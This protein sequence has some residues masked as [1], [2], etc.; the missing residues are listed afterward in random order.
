MGDFVHSGPK[1]ASIPVPDVADLIARLE[2]GELSNGLDILIEL[3]FFAAEPIA[4]RAN[5]A[6]T[7]V[8]YT[9]RDGRE[10]V[11]WARDWSMRRE[12]TIAALKAITAGGEAEG[13]VNK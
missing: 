13:G 11:C 8:V 3:A 1:G 7:K 6:G 2:K 4:C 9:Y 5:S 10:E 12:S